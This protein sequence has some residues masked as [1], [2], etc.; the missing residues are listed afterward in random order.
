MSL[1][2]LV[3][4]RKAAT[5]SGI[6]LGI[7]VLEYIVIVHLYIDLQ[8]K[9]QFAVGG[10]TT[11]AMVPVLED[12]GARLRKVATPNAETAKRTFKD[13]KKLQNLREMIKLKKRA[14][15]ISDTKP[16]EME[17]RPH[18]IT[19]TKPWNTVKRDRKEPLRHPLESDADDASYREEENHVTP[20]SVEDGAR[21]RGRGTQLRPSPVGKKPPADPLQSRDLKQVLGKPVPVLTKHSDKAVPL[22][23][24]PA[25]GARL[26]PPLVA[27]PEQSELR[28]TARTK[29][30]DN[31][32]EDGPG[33]SET[34]MRG[35]PLRMLH[36][37]SRN[38]PDGE[39]RTKVADR[40]STKGRSPIG[41]WGPP[42]AAAA[43]AGG[44]GEGE[45]HQNEEKKTSED[46]VDSLL[47]DY[48]MEMERADRDV[49]RPNARFPIDESEFEIVETEHGISVVKKQLGP[50]VLVEN[51]TRPYRTLTK[52]EKEGGNI[53]F[54]LRTT[55]SYH[56]GR[57]PLMF[58]T[59]MSETDCSRI[60][61][62]TDGYDWVTQA[63]VRLKGEL[64]MGTL[65]TSC[66]L[67]DEYTTVY[68]SIYKYKSHEISLHPN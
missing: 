67:L 2:S 23:P 3:T 5:I 42:T 39:Q 61:L 41:R 38:Q 45:Q 37:R 40:I 66:L 30:L 57:L 50:E 44:G 28:K 64:L 16:L 31:P 43:A 68:N 46:Y 25:R 13:S 19:R 14:S 11:E 56:E 22:R 10:I 55:L 52:F 26:R 18:T 65:C 27:N 47:A 24:G 1:A 8:E 48:V 17:N 54:T 62:V 21:A 6:L 58:D 60:F 36:L 53:M 12:W 51:D 7:A 49:K 34:V 33:R 63:K 59:W 4:M 29:P 35:N 15:N 32:P 20:S 9:Q